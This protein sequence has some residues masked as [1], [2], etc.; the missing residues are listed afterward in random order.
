MSENIA[1]EVKLGRIAGPFK[2]PPFENFQ[3]SPLGLI[4]KKHSEKFRTIFYLSYPKTGGSINSGI[5][6]EPY[7]LSYATIDEA[8]L[9][10]QNLG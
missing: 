5:D 7:S 2:E 8:I 3:V 1:N 9:A 10:I 4:P 6:K